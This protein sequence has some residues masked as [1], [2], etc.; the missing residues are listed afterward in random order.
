MSQQVKELFTKYNIKGHVTLP[1][2]GKSHGMIEA[3]HKSVSALI[4]ICVEEQQTANWPSLIPYIQLTL[5]QKKLC[6]FDNYSPF[7]LMFGIE[8]IR[9]RRDPPT[10]SE[11]FRTPDNT[12]AAWHKTNSA[13]QATIE[14]HFRKLQRQYDTLTLKA[15]PFPVGSFV[16]LRDLRP[17]LNKKI[18]ARYFQ[19][20]LRVMEER[21]QSLLLKSFDGRLLKVHKDN[22]KRA[23]P[24]GE[25]AFGSMPTRVK[26]ALG[27]PFA[28]SDLKDLMDREQ[29]PEFFKDKDTIPP[30]EPMQTRSRTKKVNHP[31]VK[32]TVPTDIPH[33]VDIN[34]LDDPE[35]MQYIAP[36]MLE[37]IFKE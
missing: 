3:L 7:E 28:Y 1:Y 29:I 5:N 30:P 21:P 9:S 34:H 33:M 17:I 20:P 4:R 8:P 14:K 22:C 10:E 37:T 16:Y 18:K 32:V 26:M 6:Y 35:P 11:I 12:M 25:K 19:Q 31:R 24:R 36:P 15:R 23:H 27:T 2:S 13:I